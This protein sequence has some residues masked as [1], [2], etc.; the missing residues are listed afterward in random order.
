[1]ASPYSPSRRYSSASWANAMDAGSFWTRRLNS[2]TRGFS[3]TRRLWRSY[4]AIVT[5]AVVV[6]NLPRLSRTVSRT[7]YVPAAEY[8][9]CVCA[10]VVVVFAVPSPHTHSYWVMV[11]PVPTVEPAAS[12]FTV[13]LTRGCVGDTVMLA[14]GAVGAVTVMLRV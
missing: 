7:T 13:W 3:V 2:A 10:E 1:M 11:A 8:V 5:L 6:S 4:C 12:K 14:S 9:C